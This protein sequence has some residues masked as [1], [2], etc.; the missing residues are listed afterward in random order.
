[1]IRK[2]TPF[3]WFDHQAR[4]AAEFYVSIFP[5]SKILDESVTDAKNEEYSGVDLGEAMSVSFDLSGQAFIALN[6]GPYFKFTPAVSFYVDCE[7]QAEV[8]R[9]WE[10]LTQ[11]GEP[12]QCG[13][14]TDKYGVSWQI[15]PSILPELL[16]HPDPIKAQRVMDAMLSM[17]KLNIA[18]LVDA[19]R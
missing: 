14:L 10:L 19:S 13:W 18:A 17:T 1:M 11:G 2:I 7:D 12:G 3:L 4:E 6:G 15:V 5:H 9:Y 8:D 16:A